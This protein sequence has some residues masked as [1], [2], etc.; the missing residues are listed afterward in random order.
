MTKEELLQKGISEENA[1]LIIASFSEDSKEDDSLTLLNKA[2]SDENPDESLEDLSKAE[3]GKKKEDDSED[4]K[5]DYDEKFMKTM[6]R[7]MKEK[8][9]MFKEEKEDMKKAIDEFDTNSE[10]AVVEMSDLAPILEKQAEFNEKMSKAI[11]NIA[12]NMVVVSEK[13]DKN[14]DLMQKAAKVTAEQA[15]GLKDF[16][17]VPNGRKGV[18]GSVEMQKAQKTSNEQ[19]GIVFDVLLKATK[20][21]NQ[22][23]GY[24]LSA[25]ESAGKDINK[26][27]PAHK[28]FI[29]QLLQV[30]AK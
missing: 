13:S 16:L 8:G 12:E 21:K 17:K 25:F 18:V 6:K 7:Y 15:E 4:E 29:N 28:K 27:S 14:Y 1:D 3:K 22:D 26:L 20:E 5:E 11:E 9:K 10:G 19:S 23:A 2:L 24:V 30:E